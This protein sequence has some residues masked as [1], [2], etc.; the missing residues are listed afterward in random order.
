[1]GSDRSE[2]RARNL[3]LVVGIAALIAFCCGIDWFYTA[4]CNEMEEDEEC[5]EIYDDMGSRTPLCWCK[6]WCWAPE[7]RNC[8]W[9]KGEPD[10]G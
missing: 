10:G 4:F 9:M 8:P 7:A 2:S 3:R 5:G 1:M 6:Q